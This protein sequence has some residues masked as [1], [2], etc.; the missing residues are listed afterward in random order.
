MWTR[1]VFKGVDSRSVGPRPEYQTGEPV[2][3]GV[4]K[5]L[6]N[7]IEIDVW[8]GEPADA[9]APPACPRA[10][11]LCLRLQVLD[12]IFQGV[13]NLEAGREGFPGDVIQASPEQ[14]SQLA[15]VY[16]YPYLLRTD[17]EELCQEGRLTS[18]VLVLGSPT[19]LA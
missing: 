8:S 3:P 12:G 10:G 15:P 17:D 11:L 5:G 6:E 16:D 18:A 7:H 14:A 2:I 4:L 19:L 9:G 1:G 13:L